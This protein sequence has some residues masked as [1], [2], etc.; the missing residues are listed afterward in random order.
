MPVRGTPGLWVAVVAAALGGAWTPAATAGSWRAPVPATAVEDSSA[1]PGRGVVVQDGRVWIANAVREKAFPH[2]TTGLTVSSWNLEG[3]DARSVQVDLSGLTRPA[4]PLGPQ[5]PSLNQV[6]VGGGQLQVLAGW[7]VA[8]S[9]PTEGLV[10]GPNLSFRATFDLATGALVRQEQFPAPSSGDTS[11]PIRFLAGSPGVWRQSGTFPV[12]PFFDAVTDARLPVSGGLTSTVAGRFAVVYPASRPDRWRRGHGALR[13][14]D[15]RTGRTRYRVRAR[16]LTRRAGAPGSAHPE[17][18]LYPDS[19]LGVR[20]PALGQRVRPV[21]IDG[22]G[23]IRRIGPGRRTRGLEAVSAAIH[24]QRA[25]VGLE[26]PGTGKRSE[27]D[28]RFATWIVNANGTRGLRLPAATPDGRT[29]VSALPAWWDGKHA[30]W[31]TERG[32]STGIWMQT[33]ISRQALRRGGIP[34]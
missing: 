21:A 16:T 10:S 24:G 19:S 26:L 2:P 12:R 25:V 7:V 4:A 22:R 6:R 8:S 9:D 33:G 13:V 18:I 5:F 28:A 31:A 11:P 30:L 34:H 32:T 15:L 29:R 17:V 3:R 1:D 23:H 20:V 27:P 14:V